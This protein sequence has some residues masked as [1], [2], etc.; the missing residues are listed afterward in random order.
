MATTYRDTNSDRQAI[1]TIT[2]NKK[3][4]LKRTIAVTQKAAIFNAE[5]KLSK[6]SL[7]FGSAGDRL[8]HQVGYQHRQGLDQ[9]DAYFW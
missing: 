2:A 5:F 6:S 4:D 9:S 7:S 1:I 3:S 8:Q